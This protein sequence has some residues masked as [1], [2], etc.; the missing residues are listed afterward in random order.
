MDSLEL[1]CQMVDA[2]YLVRCYISGIDNA[3]VEEYLKDPLRYVGI[4]R[5]F[6]L[7]AHYE[8]LVA[9]ERREVMKYDICRCLWRKEIQMQ[10]RYRQM[11][12]TIVHIRRV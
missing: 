2:A 4:L 3:L 10:F 9:P 6:G 5:Q 1:E 7:D 12:R 8:L 11:W